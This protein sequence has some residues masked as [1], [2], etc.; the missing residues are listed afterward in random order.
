[1]LI[2]LERI[3]KIYNGT[4]V[5]DNVSLTIEPADRVGLV[6][7][8]GCGKSTLLRI[9]TGQETPESMPQ[10]FDAVIAKAR[11]LSI[12]FLEQNSGL[13]GGSTII[14]EMTSV[15]SELLQTG[16]RLRE[17]ERLMSE[18]DSENDGRFA[19]ISHEYAQ[20]SAYF[21]ANEGYLID[22]KIKTV[23]QGM[24]FAAFGNDRIIHTLS[25]GEKTRLALAKLLL[26]RP[27]LLIL[28]E[29]T[30]HLDFR[31]IIWLEQYLSDYKGALL[32]VSHDR[33]FLDKLCTSVC[34]IERGRLTRYK[35]NYT[36]FTAAKKMAVERQ[37]KEYEAQ[38]KEIAKLQEYVDKNLVRASTSNSAKSRIH[39]LDAMERIEKPIT[40]EKPPKLEFTYAKD[41][42]KDLLSVRGID[43]S[44]GVGSERRLL[45]D[46]ISFE[47]K[48]GERLGIIGSNGV[49][50][51]TLLK[52]LQKRLPISKGRI[53]W[54]NNVRIS[55]YDQENSQINRH[56]TVMEEVHSRYPSMTE[57]QI[58]SLLGS[59]R[60][61]G[62]NVFK[63]AGV[64]SGGERAKLC[65]AIM[66]LEHG[67]VLIMD[68]PTNHLDMA[69]KEVLEQAL[70]EYTGTIIFVSHDRYLL[71]KLATRIIEITDSGIEEFK[72]NFDFYLDTTR[73]REEEREQAEAA[74]R[75]DEQA[76]AAREQ[77][78]KTY[79]TKEQRSADVQRRNRIK[80]L[81]SEIEAMHI[82]LDELTEEIASPEVCADYKLLGEK[83]ARIEELK[84]IIGDMTDEWVELSE[85]M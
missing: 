2:N 36:T 20:K 22:V 19:E 44:V 60:L 31:T 73:R 23:L 40:Y 38:Q 79:R 55:Y 82:E 33:Y 50:K 27:Q 77:Q 48:R 64:I 34:E 21:E 39:K 58:R 7:I 57:L 52:I 67:N 85:E 84:L 42:P 45:S 26:E 11:D 75:R 69:T 35:G 54:T 47:V 14:A 37:M 56:N 66:M 72:G 10:P 53:E 81:E 49:G 18:T 24:G 65:F 62:E 41:P 43:I 17:L 80:Q 15:F 4:Q 25:G 74:L 63:P 32:I 70:C 68:E 6:G 46:D 9:I 71:N 3:S 29:P 16:E 30:N 59:V 61:V 78:Q 5:L 8:N 83:C 28:D 12:G 76:K 1:M 13:D 51:S